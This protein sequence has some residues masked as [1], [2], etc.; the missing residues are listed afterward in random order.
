MAERS[1]LGFI[2]TKLSSS[3]E[4]IATEALCYILQ[5]SKN[6]RSGLVK[7][8]TPLIDLKS[9]VFFRTQVIGEKKEIPDLVGVDFENHEIL[10]IESK[11]WAG[12]TSNQPVTYLK[13]LPQRSAMLLFIAPDRRLPTLWPELRRRCHEGKG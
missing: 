4:N 5:N 11:F 7:Y 9:D 3:P 8:L 1:L 2:S 6:A 12:L 13:R 10:I